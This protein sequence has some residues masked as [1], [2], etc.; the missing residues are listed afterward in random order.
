MW[1]IVKVVDVQIDLVLVYLSASGHAS[2]PLIIDE[3]PPIAGEVNDGSEVEYDL[4]FTK[5]AHE[6]SDVFYSE[7]SYL[8]Y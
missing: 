4:T 8:Y 3:S 2:N 6:V 1:V 5:E 7:S